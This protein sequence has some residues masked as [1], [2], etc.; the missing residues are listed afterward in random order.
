[1]YTHQFPIWHLCDSRYR[2]TQK[3][4]AEMIKSTAK[5]DEM[6]LAKSWLLDFVS[7]A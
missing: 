5:N 6:L 2:N 3:T 7:N 1:M 4:I